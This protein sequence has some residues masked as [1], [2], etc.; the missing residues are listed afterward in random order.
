LSATPGQIIN[1]RLIFNHSRKTAR[2]AFE[3]DPGSESA[4]E[5][6]LLLEGNEGPLSETWLYRWTP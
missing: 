2:V 6:R 3:L 4:I 5:L 1:P